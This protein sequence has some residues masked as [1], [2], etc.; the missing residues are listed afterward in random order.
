MLASLRRVMAFLTPFGPA[1][2]PE[3][4]DLWYFPMAGA[5]IGLILGLLWWL[6]AKAWYPE[7][8]AALLVIGDLVITGMLHVDGL[9]DSADGLLA[10]HMERSRRLAIMTEP[11]VG[12]FAVATVAV[13][14]LARW[15]GADN[16]VASPFLIGGLWCASRTIMAVAI[17][18]L[19]YARSEGGLASAFVGSDP[20]P[21]LVGS[22]G[23]VVSL[24]LV[25]VWKPGPGAAALGAAILAALG[26][27]EIGRRRLGGFTG[28]VLGA[29]AVVGE[30]VGLLVAAARW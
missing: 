3:A 25:L 28:D 16:I 10:P 15:A 9:A 17:D 4:G 22:L 20:Q 30:T 1:A 8:G 27:L 13:V 24:V 6:V 2:V 26:V 29:A 11:T 18:V 14:L 23:L 5:S 12:A 7:V 19:P 21:W